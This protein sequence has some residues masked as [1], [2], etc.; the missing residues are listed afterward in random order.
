MTADHAELKKLLE[1]QQ[2]ELKDGGVQY[3]AASV[4][5]VVHPRNPHA[6]TGHF[7]Y[8][9]FEL[10]EEH[11]G[12]F[13]PKLWWFGGGGDLTPYV[14]H[15]EDASHFHQVHKDVCDIHNP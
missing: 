15:H 11:D 14:L 4:S 13:Y 10:G 3:F 5:S 7:N 9:Y 12:K 8:R 2:I 6:P 1:T